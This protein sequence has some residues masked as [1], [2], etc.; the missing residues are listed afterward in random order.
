MSPC[1]PFRAELERALA[2]PAGELARLARHEHV[3]ACG[4]CRAELARERDLER[5]LDRLPAPAVPSALARRVRARLANERGE[6]LAVADD[7]EP[8]ESELEKL[9]ERVP[10]PRVPAGLGERVLRGVAAEREARRAKPERR[11]WLLV[12]AAV[13]LAALALWGWNALPRVAPRGEV[14]Q[15][16]PAMLEDDEELVAYAVERWELLHDEDLDLLLASLD[17][18]DELLIEYAVDES[19]LED[20]SGEAS[21]DTAPLRTDATDGD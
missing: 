1:A 16:A 9:L 11:A 3:L 5:L 2:G 4:S 18:A 8:A 15:G 17:P 21:P 7:T 10:A 20:G 19:W 6:P 14:A 13:L 12:A